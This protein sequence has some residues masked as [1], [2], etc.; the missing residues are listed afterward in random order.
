MQIFRDSSYHSVSHAVTKF[1]IL[2][3]G[4]Q[5]VAVVVCIDSEASQIDVK[6]VAR[7]NIGYRQVSNQIG[8]LG[9]YA[10]R[11][12]ILGLLFVPVLVIDSYEGARESQYLAE[13]NEHAVVYLRQRRQNE[14]RCEHR[15]PEDAQCQ[16]G[17]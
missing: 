12:T 13:G 8:I 2:S 5:L 15:A 16:C 1:A 3:N 17:Y 10:E 11:T 4:I 14:A 9:K 6:K 7:S